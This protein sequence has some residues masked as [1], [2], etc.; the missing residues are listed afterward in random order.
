M[1][2]T[3]IEIIEKT[4]NA[5]DSF[6]AGDFV[7]QINNPSEFDVIYIALKNSGIMDCKQFILFINKI[8]LLKFLKGSFPISESA[9]KIVIHERDFIKKGDFLIVSEEKNIYGNFAACKAA[10]QITT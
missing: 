4:I 6:I 9:P 1:E 10:L 5:A 7:A 3:D 8:D 2:N